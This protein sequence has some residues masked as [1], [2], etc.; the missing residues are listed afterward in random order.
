MVGKLRKTI[1]T[2][3]LPQ[4]GHLVTHYLKVPYS[5]EEDKE[6]KLA[7]A[8]TEHWDRI[9]DNQKWSQL[10]CYKFGKLEAKPIAM[11]VKL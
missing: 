8:L 1:E 2:T 5:T 3:G 11:K 10:D 4:E 7:L 6:A 9:L